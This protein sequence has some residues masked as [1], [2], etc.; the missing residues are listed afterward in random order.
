MNSDISC[1]KR[2]G[3][4]YDFCQDESILMNGEGI[5]I[6]LETP[7]EHYYYLHYPLGSENSYMYR[8]QEP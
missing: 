1:E 2:D 7:D 8:L 5:L 3:D 6:V 4:G